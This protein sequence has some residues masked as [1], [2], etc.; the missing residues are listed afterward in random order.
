MFPPAVKVKRFEGGAIS[1]FLIFVKILSLIYPRPIEGHVAS[2]F[3]QFE[4][5]KGM[6]ELQVFLFSLFRPPP[7]G[8]RRT[9]SGIFLK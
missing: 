2:T 7:G 5:H 1:F 6:D 4:L 9:I 8:T 3:F